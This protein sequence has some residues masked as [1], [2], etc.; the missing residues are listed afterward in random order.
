MKTVTKPLKTAENQQQITL[1]FIKPP[2]IAR[3]IIT[4]PYKLLKIDR[5]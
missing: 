3:K 4:E 5:K 2:K 1:K